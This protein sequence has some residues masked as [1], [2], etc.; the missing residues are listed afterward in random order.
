MGRAAPDLAKGK[1]SVGASLQFKARCVIAE[2][3]LSARC[4]ELGIAL[5]DPLAGHPALAWLDRTEGR[6]TRG[7]RR[8]A[9]KL[10]A[11]A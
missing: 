5:I 3:L 9:R 10:R 7:M 2:K 1:F 6:M 8:I 4:L 11:L